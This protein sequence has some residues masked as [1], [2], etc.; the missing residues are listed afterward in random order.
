ML[1]LALVPDFYRSTAAALHRAHAL[2]QRADNDGRLY[3]DGLE[4]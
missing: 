3:P 1:F 4:R 2:G